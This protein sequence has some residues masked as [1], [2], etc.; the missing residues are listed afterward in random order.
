MVVMI[1]EDDLGQSVLSGLK[2]C[3]QLEVVPNRVANF[4]K[5][6]GS[7][8]VQSL[9]FCSTVVVRLVPQ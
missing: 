4:S 5:G 7:V 2:N 1:D 8:V 9:M 3:P 6:R